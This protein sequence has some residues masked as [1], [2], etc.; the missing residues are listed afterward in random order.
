MDEGT[1]GADGG[2]VVICRP[3]PRPIPITVRSSPVSILVPRPLPLPP[4]DEADITTGVLLTSY[5]ALTLEQ[6][7]YHVIFLF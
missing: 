4:P 2:G 5:N 1:E 7:V 3:L 6:T